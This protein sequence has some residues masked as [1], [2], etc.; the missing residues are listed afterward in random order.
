MA[1]NAFQGFLGR[2]NRRKVELL[3]RNHSVAA[4]FDGILDRLVDHANARGGA[5]D[6]LDIRDAFIV[7]D[8]DTYIKARVV[9]R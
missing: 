5:F 6:Q 2:Y 8:A 7:W 9:C 4:F 1:D 3:E